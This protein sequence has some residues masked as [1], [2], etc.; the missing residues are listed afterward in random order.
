M[1]DVWYL[2]P[3]SIA[4]Y[5]TIPVSLVGEARVCVYIRVYV[6]G[7]TLLSLLPRSST[8]NSLGIGCEEKYAAWPRAF[9]RGSSFIR[10]SGRTWPETLGGK[11]VRWL[12]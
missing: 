10:K 8:E 3:L 2:G 12:G 4:N 1:E 9:S 11:T 6:R 5:P 7:Y